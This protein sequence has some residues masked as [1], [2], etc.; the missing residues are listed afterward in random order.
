MSKIYTKKGD[1]GQALSPD[2]LKN[3]DDIIFELFGTIDEAQAHVGM[4]YELL[5]DGVPDRNANNLKENLREHE[6]ALRAIMSQ[7][8]KIS[9]S[10]FTKRDLSIPD[11]DKTLEG[12][13][14]KMDETLEPLNHFILPIGSKISSQTHITRAV[15]RRLERLFVH[16]DSENEYTV[17][18]VF[19]N[20]LS[21]YLF[22]LA[23]YLE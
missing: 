7:L 22:T 21:D 16:W 20:R 6:F 11:F 2:G 5:M 12:W 10:V 18:R 14:D 4:I 8:Y 17:T 19:L 9:G 13:I 15:V 23:R 1:N 3:K